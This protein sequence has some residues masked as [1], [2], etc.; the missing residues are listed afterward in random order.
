MWK[1]IHKADKILDC[2]NDIYLDKNNF[3]HLAYHKIQK[4]KKTIDGLKF[5]MH[6][7]LQIMMRDFAVK[8]IIYVIKKKLNNG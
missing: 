6:L 3:I 4:Y 1:E 2:I 5:Y 8:V 7:I